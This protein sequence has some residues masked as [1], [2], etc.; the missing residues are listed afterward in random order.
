MSVVLLGEGDERVRRETLHS[1][2]RHL[3]RWGRSVLGGDTYDAQCLGEIVTSRAWREH[4]H[5]NVMGGWFGVAFTASEAAVDALQQMPM[6]MIEDGHPPARPAAV[7]GRHVTVVNRPVERYGDPAPVWVMR[8][9]SHQYVE[10]AGPKPIEERMSDE[11]RDWCTVN[12]LTVAYPPR[13][14]WRKV[15]DGAR[16]VFGA[17]YEVYARADTVR[18]GRVFL[19]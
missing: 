12:G 5:S 11:L 1:V 8:H 15:D 13:L 6:Q 19:G 9:V 18:D 7:F 16:H 3:D 17:V 14:E 2:R 4:A 10:R